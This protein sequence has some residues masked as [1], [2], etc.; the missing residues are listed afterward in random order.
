[1]LICNA[2]QESVMK[3]E[4][5]IRYELCDLQVEFLRHLATGVGNSIRY[6]AEGLARN[7]EAFGYVVWQVG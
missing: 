5:R 7:H 6:D 2:G 4:S 3:L 1:M